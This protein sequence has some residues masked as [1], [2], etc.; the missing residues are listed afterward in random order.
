MYINVMQ[1]LPYEKLQ[2]SLH[3][4]R[5]NHRLL[6]DESKRPTLWKDFL[7]QNTYIIIAK[8]RYNYPSHFDTHKKFNTSF[9]KP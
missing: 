2:R 9:I 6:L 5:Q 4:N 1:M 8:T 7:N 3:Q